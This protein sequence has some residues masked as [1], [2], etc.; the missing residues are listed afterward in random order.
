MLIKHKK[1]G[2]H[3]EKVAHACK[4]ISNP[5]RIIFQYMHPEHG[6]GSHGKPASKKP[7]VGQLSR[8]KCPGPSEFSH[9]CE[10]KLEHHLTGAEGSAKEPEVSLSTYAQQ[11]E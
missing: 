7:P 9:L 6:G 5:E 8:K 10:R 2:K 3:P 4:R 11:Y 1:C